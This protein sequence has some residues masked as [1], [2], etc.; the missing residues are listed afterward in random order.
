MHTLKGFEFNNKHI[1]VLV[2]NIGSINLTKKL[3]HY[4]RI[5][6]D[7]VSEHVT[8]GDIVLDYIKYKLN[9]S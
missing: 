4:S 2:D 5:K 8:R 1:K 3:I 6:H 7:F 9:F